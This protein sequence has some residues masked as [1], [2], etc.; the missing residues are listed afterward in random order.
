M[1]ELQPFIIDGENPISFSAVVLN[2]SSNV[3]KLK[4]NEVLNITVKLGKKLVCLTSFN[5]SFI[6]VFS[7]PV[8]ELSNIV[9]DLH[10]LLLL[11]MIHFIAFL[12]IGVRD[13]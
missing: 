3:N 11:Q 1:F 7:L 9:L 2:V 12:F 8:V 5:Y 10:I 13:R 4:Q 6:V